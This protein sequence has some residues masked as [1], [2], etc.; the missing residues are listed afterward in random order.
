MRPARRFSRRVRSY[1]PDRRLSRLNDGMSALTMGA[2]LTGLFSGS[3]EASL[4][5]YALAF[6]IVT[7]R[8]KFWIDD[9]AFF[10]DPLKGG[11]RSDRFFR[12]GMTFAIASWVMFIVAGV[13][14]RDPV[15]AGAWLLGALLVSTAWLVAEIVGPKSYRLQAL[16]SASNAGYVTLAIVLILSPWL[17]G[18]LGVEASW[19][20]WFAIVGMALVLSVEIIKADW[21]RSAA[22]QLGGE[23]GAR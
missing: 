14:V 10:E 8:V 18:V 19:V 9:M 7:M 20:Q 1:G 22:V 11:D 4:V 21:L 23:I 6:L 13:M 15:V 16:W 17:G 3:S 5:S 12:I 2:P